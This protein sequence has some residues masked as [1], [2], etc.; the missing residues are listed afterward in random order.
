MKKFVYAIVLTMC[1]FLCHAQSA[2]YDVLA[3]AGN[4][5]RFWNGNDNYKIHMGSA[6]EYFYGPITVYSI[7]TQLPNTPG[8]GFTWGTAGQ[9]PTAA[10]STQGTFQLAGDLL[11]QGNLGITTTTPKTSLQISDGWNQV[12][13]GNIAQAYRQTLNWASQYVGFNMV[14]TANG[15]ETYPDGVNNGGT[16]MMADPFGC[17]RFVG[18]S[19]SGNSS[20]TLDNTAINS[21]TR[22][23]ITGWG[24]VGI[25]TVNP[26]AALAVNGQVHAEEVKVDTNV[27]PDYVFNDDYTLRPLAEVQGYIRENHHLPEIPSAKEME[28]D[29]V[30]LGEMNMLLLKKVEELTLY[31][32]EQ[33]KRIKDLEGTRKRRR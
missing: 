29:G 2:Y 27:A 21:A 9:T 20:R 8:W 28:T 24:T 14:R 18:V 26:D 7:K 15:W 1:V 19:S 4:G 5:I 31:I 17:I 3:G 12:N 25:G 13:I 16:M 23:I 6:S 10:L 33:D 30:K 11:P 32:L 22:M